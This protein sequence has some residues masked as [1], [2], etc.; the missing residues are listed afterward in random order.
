MRVLIFVVALILLFSLLGWI[1]FSKSSDRSSVNIETDTIRADTNKAIQSGATILKG[2]GDKIENEVP[3]TEMHE[4][5]F[6]ESAPA[7]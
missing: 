7:K 5:K 4:S 3:K 2:A 1:T 6:Q